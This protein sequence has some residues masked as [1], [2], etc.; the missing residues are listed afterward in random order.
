[1][2]HNSGVSAVC[3]NY[4]GCLWV[5]P[6][7]VVR[8]RMNSRNSQYNAAKTS[9]RTAFQKKCFGRINFVRISKVDLIKWRGVD[10]FLHLVAFSRAVD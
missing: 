10:L 6:R 8:I 7:K 3:A 9:T 1:M 5:S 2:H 4:D